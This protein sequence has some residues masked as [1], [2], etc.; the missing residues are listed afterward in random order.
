MKVTRELFIFSFFF[1]FLFAAL[2]FIYLLKVQKQ[3]Y[4]RR[5]KED[6]SASVATKDSSAYKLDCRPQASTITSNIPIRILRAREFQ[7]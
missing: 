1:S 6:A 7:R 3:H 4:L 2:N 5:G